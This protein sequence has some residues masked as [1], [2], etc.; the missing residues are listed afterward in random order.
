MRALYWTVLIMVCLTTLVL[1]VKMLMY[2]AKVS[3]YYLGNL[4][5]WVNFWNFVAVGFANYSQCND[6]DVRLVGGISQYRGRVEVC[7]NKA[8][9]TVCAYS[10]WGSQEAKIVCRQIGAL[11]IGIYK[12]PF[13]LLI[14]NYCRLFIWPCGKF[15]ILTRHW[16][17]SSWILELCW[18]RS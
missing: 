16:T 14:H 7:L 4:N 15:G 8:W 11:T 18:N 17:H 10:N 5:I 9:G 6:G 2:F 12:V 1:W 3:I 13:I